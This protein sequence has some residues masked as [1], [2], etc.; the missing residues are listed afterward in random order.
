MSPRGIVGLAALALACRAG[1]GSG[2]GGLGG[3]TG[4]GESAPDDWPQY[5]HDVS[6]SSASRESFADQAAA[7]LAAVAGLL[8]AYLWT[9]S[10][11]PVACRS[12]VK[13]TVPL[14]GA[15]VQDIDC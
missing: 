9:S 4:G 5:R 7:C 14:G 2:G 12:A 10:E 8:C 1:S 11:D 13:G 3:G 15:C 6:G